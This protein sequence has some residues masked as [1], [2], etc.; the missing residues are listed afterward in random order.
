[1]PLA[2][3]FVLAC[4]FAVADLAGCSGGPHLVCA[5]RAKPEPAYALDVTMAGQVRWQVPLGLP[6]SGQQP[7]PLAA[8]AV[9]VFAQSNVL[10]R[11][12]AGELCNSEREVRIA[13]PTR[14]RPRTHS[15][16][17][18]KIGRFTWA[19]KRSSFPVGNAIW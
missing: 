15:F 13:V 1:V 16:S 7:S 4:A 8:G 12:R 9:A 2:C 17:A 19:I 5:C 6:G 3:S 10:I 11:G 14:D 18:A